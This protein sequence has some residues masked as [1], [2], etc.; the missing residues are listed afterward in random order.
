MKNIDRRG[1]LPDGLRLP[2]C[3]RQSAKIGCTRVQRWILLSC[4]GGYFESTTDRFTRVQW[5]LSLSC[6]LRADYP[7][8]AARSG[9]RPN[10][11][12]PSRHC[13]GD[14]CDR[15]MCRHIATMR[16]EYKIRPYRPCRA[17]CNCAKP[18]RHVSKEGWPMTSIICTAWLTCSSA[19]ARLHRS[20]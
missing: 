6:K 13:R 16:G 15:P 14:P 2:R 17:A 19:G 4:N 7:C 1:V 20:S 5:L 9:V 3:P 11:P 8:R 18:L 12:A 10:A